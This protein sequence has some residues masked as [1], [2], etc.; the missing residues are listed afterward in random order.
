MRRHVT[1][2]KFMKIGAIKLL[3]ESPSMLRLGRPEIESRWAKAKAAND[4][5]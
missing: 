4:I 2:A 3:Q 1:L 5:L